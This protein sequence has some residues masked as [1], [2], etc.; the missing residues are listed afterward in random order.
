MYYSSMGWGFRG[1]HYHLYIESH[2]LMLQFFLSIYKKIE[3]SK[4]NMHVSISI[5]VFVSY[6]WMSFTLYLGLDLLK[7]V[8]EISELNDAFWII[9]EILQLICLVHGHLIE[10][11]K[12]ISKHKS[13]STK[14]RYFRVIL[15]MNVSLEIAIGTLLVH[16]HFSICCINMIEAPHELICFP[17]PTYDISFTKNPILLLIWPFVW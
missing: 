5:W 16:F 1:L 15:N 8:M 9:L 10:L 2:V 4:K 11:L 3:K 6:F 17:L 14:V 13:S 7:D 12:L